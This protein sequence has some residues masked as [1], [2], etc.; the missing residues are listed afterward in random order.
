[1]F[2]NVKGSIYRLPFRVRNFF[3]YWKVRIIIFW[4]RFIRWQWTFRKSDFC[5]VGLILICIGISLGML[6]RSKQVEPRLYAHIQELTDQRL[7]MIAMMGAAEGRITALERQMRLAGLNIPPA[8]K[9]EQ[10]SSK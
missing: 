5:I 7:S 4:V 10:I 8:N 2:Q 1:M 3:H 9:V 6:W